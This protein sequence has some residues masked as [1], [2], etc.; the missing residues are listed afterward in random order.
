MSDAR[1]EMRPQP[2]IIVPDFS[3][4]SVDLPDVDH[5]PRPVVTVSA[6]VSTRWEHPL[7]QHRRSHLIYS[8]RGVLN[9]EVE[10]GAWIVPP[11]CALWI[12]GSTPYSIRGTGETE[13]YCLFVEPDAAPNLPRNCCTLAVS[14]LMR[15]LLF[16]VSQFPE[17]YPLGGK[18]ELTVSLL[19]EELSAARY[20]GFYFPMPSHPRLRQLAEMLRADPADNAPI[21]TWAKRIC[22]TERTMS[23]ILRDEIGMSFG[24]WRRQLH[25][26]LALQ[27]L[28]QGETVQAIA[29]QLGYE[30]AS[31]FV[32]MFR[33]AVGTS[34]AKFLADCLERTKRW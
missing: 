12:P 27:L 21:V 28:S 5:I 31:G 25:I 14:P 2:K 4:S 6:V 18:E 19:L 3:S 33:K 7:H 10:R 11:N 9:C 34:P 26:V 17:L 1:F 13:T 32:T 30:S 16:E 29:S 22:M 23:R 24:R 8:V 20:E 15:E